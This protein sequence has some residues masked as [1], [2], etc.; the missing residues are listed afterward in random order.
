MCNFQSFIYN[1]HRFS[2][3]NHEHIEWFACGLTITDIHVVERAGRL[4]GVHMAFAGKPCCIS[5]DRVLGLKT[6]QYSTNSTTF[7][8]ATMRSF[9]F[10]SRNRRSI[11]QEL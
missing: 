8:V 2:L 11:L 1:P 10:V 7:G 4:V 6:L 3:L 5:K 9:H